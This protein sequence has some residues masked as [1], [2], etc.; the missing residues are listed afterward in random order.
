MKKIMTVLLA[1]LMIVAL[2]SCGNNAVEKTQLGTSGIFIVLPEG[3]VATEDAFDDDQVAYYYKDDESIDFDVY[4]WAKGDEYDL[5]EEAA[6]YAEEYGTTA[7]AVTVNGVAGMKYVS[8][9]E[10]EASVY[11]VINYMFDDGKNIVELCFWTTNSE[12]ELAAVDEII[13]TITVQ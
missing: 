9:E 6:Y 2:A 8:V 12:E 3:F 7:S 13:N 4:Q 11:T 5:E 1:L 10:Y